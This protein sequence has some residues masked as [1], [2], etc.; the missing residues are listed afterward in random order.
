MQL[1]LSPAKNLNEQA[2]MPT[3]G[4]PTDVPR[5]LQK[6]AAIMRTLKTYDPIMLQDLQGISAKL[7]EQ[8]F[9]RNQMWHADFGKSD[10]IS[11]LY[12]FNGDVYTGLD[13]QNLDSK[14][15][16]YLQKYLWILSGLY[17][18]LRPLD[19]ILPYRLEMGTRLAV[20]DNANLYQFWG[21]LLGNTIAK[22][23]DMLIN[24]ASDEYFK[25]LQLPT[26]VQ[27]ITMRFEDFSAGKFKV[28]SFYAKRARGLMA[29]FAAI[30]QATSPD[31]LQAFDLDGYQFIREDGNIWLYRRKV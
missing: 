21:D 12:L 26:S 1:I 24:L 25:S 10:A 15:V 13:A 5:F 23:T 3:F 31:A 17:G 22:H 20:D 30:K 6:S 19:A 27:V 9:T 14:A 29:R 2:P 8:N 11:A 16:A 28:V 18:L 4:K 7:S